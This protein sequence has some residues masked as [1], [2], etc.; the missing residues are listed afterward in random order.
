MEQKKKKSI[1]KLL[2]NTIPQKRQKIY[3]SL[4]K[5]RSKQPNKQ[6]KKQ[7]TEKLN[8]IAKQSNQEKNIFLVPLCYNNSFCLIKQW[9]N[10][11]FHFIFCVVF[12]SYFNGTL[13]P[14]A[15]ATTTQNEGK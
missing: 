8:I 3:C 11:L 15:P 7:L 14:T 12:L 9:V 1:I 6:K 5:T 10:F 4:K 2:F 13:C